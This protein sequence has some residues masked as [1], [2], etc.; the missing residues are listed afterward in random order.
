MSSVT[1]VIEAVARLIKL[2]DIEALEQLLEPWDV[3]NQEALLLEGIKLNAI[4]DS[5]SI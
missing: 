1:E 3:E 2:D 4:A 5:R